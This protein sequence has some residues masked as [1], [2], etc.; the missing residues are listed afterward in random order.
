MDYLL[1]KVNTYNI[2]Q[3]IL[4]IIYYPALYNDSLIILSLLI[5]LDINNILLRY[6]LIQS[7]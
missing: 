3:Y 1:S 6:T 2:N 4:F 5:L 7:I